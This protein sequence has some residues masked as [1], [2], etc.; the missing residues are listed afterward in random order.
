MPLS[1]KRMPWG[2]NSAFTQTWGMLQRRPPGWTWR[3]SPLKCLCPRLCALHPLPCWVSQKTHSQALSLSLTL[4]SRKANCAVQRLQDHLRLMGVLLA[5][6]ADVSFWM[7]TRM[8]TR[9]KFYKKCLTGAGGEIGEN[10][11]RQE[12]SLKTVSLHLKTFSQPVG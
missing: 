11:G 9:K 10:A 12:W 5:H 1:R 7:T 6:L 4:R 2:R 3:P 8:K